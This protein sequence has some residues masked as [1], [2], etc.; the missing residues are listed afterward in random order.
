[1]GMSLPPPWLSVIFRSFG[2]FSPDFCRHMHT[3]P[4]SSLGS[5]SALLS[6]TLQ[7]CRVH[8]QTRKVKQQKAAILATAW[9]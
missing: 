9:P 1:M 4:N 2:S 5:V 8:G 3:A 7:G 6:L